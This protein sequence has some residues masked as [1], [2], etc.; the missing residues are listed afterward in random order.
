MKAGDILK[1]LQ[2]KS[3]MKVNIISPFLVIDEKTEALEIQSWH[4]VVAGREFGY[5]I[6]TPA[7]FSIVTFFCLF[8][9]LSLD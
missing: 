4:C 8:F 2:I 5:Q 7:F 3:F 9:C 1:S 6:S